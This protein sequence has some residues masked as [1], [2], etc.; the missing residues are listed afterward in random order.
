ME[1]DEPWFRWS[2]SISYEDLT[3]YVEK[4]LSSWLKGNPSYYRLDGDEETI[5]RIIQV[6]VDSRSKGGVIKSLSLRGEKG[7]LF[8]T[9]EYQIRKVLCP[10]ETELTLKDGNKKVC[11]MIPFIKSSK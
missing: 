6:K 11:T 9:G 2:G 3:E 10:E 8:V 7:T 5:G 1:K 4:N